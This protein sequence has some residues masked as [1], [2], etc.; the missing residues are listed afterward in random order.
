MLFEKYTDPIAD[1]YYNLYD[2]WTVCHQDELFFSLGRGNSPRYIGF[3]A[4]KSF[5]RNKW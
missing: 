1:K 2:S 5:V 4:T 3:L